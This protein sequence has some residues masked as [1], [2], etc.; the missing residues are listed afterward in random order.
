[1]RPEPLVKRYHL[2]LTPGPSFAFGTPI[3]NSVGFALYD[4]PPEARNG[5]PRR[6]SGQSGPPGA[7]NTRPV[8]AKP[9]EFAI[10]AAT[11]EVKADGRGAGYGILFVA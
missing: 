3:A 9:T 11:S 5:L 4:C 10:R 2:A 6:F 1:M 7:E 8:S